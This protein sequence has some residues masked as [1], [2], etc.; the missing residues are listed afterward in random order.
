MIMLL[1][2]HF[3][4][5]ANCGNESGFVRHHLKDHRCACNALSKLVL[6]LFSFAFYFHRTDDTFDSL[7]VTSESRR[8][9]VVRRG[10]RLNLDGLSQG[11]ILKVSLEKVY[12][13]K[14]FKPRPSVTTGDQTFD[15]VAVRQEHLPLHHRV[16]PRVCVIFWFLRCFLPCFLPCFSSSSV[17]GFKRLTPR[18][19]S[20]VPQTHHSTSSRVNCWPSF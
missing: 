7:Y 20:S 17:G 14:A 2:D 8:P 16:A 4:P 5:S 1:S 11:T 10:R 3:P 15:H 18:R 6:T 9:A 13:E 12:I 19:N